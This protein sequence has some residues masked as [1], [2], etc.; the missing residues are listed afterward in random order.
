MGR[1]SVFLRF[2]D[3]KVF[4]FL[5]PF[6]AMV[7]FLANSDNRNP[8]EFDINGKVVITNW[9]GK[10]H[11]MPLIV[12]KQFNDAGTEVKLETGDLL[13]DANNVKVGDTFEKKTG[14]KMCII[15]GQKIRC[16]K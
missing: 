11:G 5:T 2:K 4:I 14:S 1:R 6:V 3:P 13:L 9:E 15:S 16:L 8:I 12:I 10:N 7:G